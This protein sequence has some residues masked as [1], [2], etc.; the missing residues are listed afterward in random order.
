MND[1]MFKIAILAP[2]ALWLF[3]VL[4]WQRLKHLPDIKERA[5]SVVLDLGSIFF[6]IALVLAALAWAVGEV[7]L[8]AVA[9]IAYAI[10]TLMAVPWYFYLVQESKSSLHLCDYTVPGWLLVGKEWVYCSNYPVRYFRNWWYRVCSLSVFFPA[11][12]RYEEKVEKNNITGQTSITFVLEI[13]QREETLLC[14]PQTFHQTC[15][16]ICKALRAASL[17]LANHNESEER[18]GE[19]LVKVTNKEA[20]SAPNVTANLLNVTVDTEQKKHTRVVDTNV[21]CKRVLT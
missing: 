2:M 6:V 3:S 19:T 5:D 7:G 11:K 21:V 1:A 16:D 14:A 4:R 18:I 15:V 12:R 20:E 13:I 9:V 10:A 17:E 8:G